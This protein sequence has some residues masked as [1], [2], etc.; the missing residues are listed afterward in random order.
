MD[1]ANDKLGTGMNVIHWQSRCAEEA[2]NGGEDNRSRDAGSG[3]QGALLRSVESMMLGC[4]ALRGGA[5][6]IGVSRR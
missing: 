5:C 3:E 4:S 6:A 1:E 2:V